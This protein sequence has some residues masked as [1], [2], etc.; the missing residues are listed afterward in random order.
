[1]RTPMTLRTADDEVVL[2]A[3]A[4]LPYV[5]RIPFR[6][7]APRCT[8]PVV[9]R[10]ALGT[11]VI[12]PVPRE[13]NESTSLEFD[14][15]QRKGVQCTLPNV[16]FTIEENTVGTLTPLTLHNTLPI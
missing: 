10:V 5:L 16:G 11:N 2:H 12:K 1:M 6:E 9:N 8:R 14:N 13:V 7:A 3:F 4:L 15:E